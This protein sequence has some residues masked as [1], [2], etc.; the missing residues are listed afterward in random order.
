MNKQ[1][2]STSS[3]SK[4]P[5]S[6]AG[7]S[8]GAN[9]GS[10]TGAAA[11]RAAASA[12]VTAETIAESVQTLVDQGAETIDT[13]KARVSEVTDGA[14]EKGAALIDRTTK[15]VKEHPLAALAVAFSAGYIAMRITTSRITQLGMIGGVLYA[16]SR[17]FRA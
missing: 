17:L 11:S 4:A 2:A 5:I 9:A 16:G 13:I 14:R 6:N 1:T 12:E 8:S 3:S 7:S 10:N 15:L